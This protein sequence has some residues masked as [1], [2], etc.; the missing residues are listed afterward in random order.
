MKRKNPK[1]S[2]TKASKTI[3][4][5]IVNVEKPETMIAWLESMSSKAKQWGAT[6]TSIYFHC[7]FSEETSRHYLTVAFMGYKY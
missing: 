6:D 3:G 1:A 7:Y 2:K 4:E 5:K